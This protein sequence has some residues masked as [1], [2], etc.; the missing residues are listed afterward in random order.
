[1]FAD[2]Y[3]V[4]NSRLSLILCFIA[5]MV[6]GF[7]LVTNGLIAPKVAP[8]FGMGPGDL[9]LL[10]GLTSLGMLFGA[11]TGGMLGDRFGPKVGLLQALL[12][13]G[14]AS[15][16]SAL[17]FS[18]PTLIA[19][20][21]L[22]GLGIGAALPNVLSYVATLS[23]PGRSAG[24]GTI[25]A[26]AVPVGGGVAGFLIFLFP[27]NLSWQ[28][29][30]VIGGILPLT[31]VIPLAVLLPAVRFSPHPVADRQSLA[32]L[33]NSKRRPLTLTLW[34]ASF[35][36][37]SVFY[38]L[39][40]WLPTFFGQ[41]GLNKSQAGLVMLIFTYTGAASAVAFGFLLNK[42]GRTK[43]LSIL[44]FG[45]MAFGAVVLQMVGPSLE[46]IAIAAVIA[47]AF[48]SGAQCLLLGVCPTIYP[49]ALRGRGAGAAIAA[50]R[51]GAIVGPMSAGF[52]LAAGATH[53][54]VYWLI[55]P[56]A[57]IA[58]VAMLSLLKMAG[59]ET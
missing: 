24:I 51:M 44:G 18:A 13:F 4:G 11:I 52:I 43:A 1:M 16:L 17:A 5:L 22:T 33:F 48:S 30:V 10:F 53:G 14:T 31:L 36:T 50:G 6:D 59:S 56:V 41:M 39:I 20:R 58:L 54:T 29:I 38:I 28:A 35:L 21:V 15:L 57:I 27:S 32:D 40:N 8:E 7:D 46:S 25:M 42:P 9:G 37:M 49:L 26:A 55:V 19:M 47:S 12:T 34:V 23:A 2:E 45:G 3:R